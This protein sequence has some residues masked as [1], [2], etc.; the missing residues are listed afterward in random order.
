MK[1]ITQ[2]DRLTESFNTKM[3]KFFKEFHVGRFLRAAN[4]NKLKGFAV[5]Q[6][7]LLAVSILFQHRSLYMQMHL[8]QKS[9]PFAKDTFYRFMNSSRTNWRR[10]NWRTVLLRCRWVAGFGLHRCLTA[11]I[12]SVMA[13][14][15]AKMC[16]TFALKHLRKLIMPV[17]ERV[18]YVRSLSS[19]I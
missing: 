16:M 14:N 8:H 2:D 13:G 15:P 18:F 17:S 4:A 11:D 12:A 10:F 7:F 6:I 3:S 9:L 1:S 19:V 5:V